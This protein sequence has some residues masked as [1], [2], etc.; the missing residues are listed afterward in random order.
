MAIPTESEPA[1]RW[2][3]AARRS[4]LPDGPTTTLPRSIRTPTADFVDVLNGRSSTIGS[5]LTINDLSSL[6]WHSTFL[7]ARRPGRFGIP[8]ESRSAPS[9]G[10]LHPIRLLVLPIEDGAPFGLFDQAAHALVGISAAALVANR[11]SV[12]NILGDVGGATI[13][14]AADQALL[15]GC[16][17][18]SSSLMWRDA[19]ALTATICLVATA[20]GLVATPIGR[21]GEAIVRAAG[22]PGEFVGA[23]AVQV[24]SVKRR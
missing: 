21:I 6:L 11:E 13:Q 3:P 18:N 7:R 10:G 23:G 12:L 24:G 14:M 1:P 22:M 9:A 17:E 4:P 2:E 20:L 15:E 16:Y 5:A 19:G 8:W